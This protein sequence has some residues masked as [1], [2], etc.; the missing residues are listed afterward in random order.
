MYVHG[1]ITHLDRRIGQE[2]WAGRF[3]TFCQCTLTQPLNRP[4]DGDDLLHF[5]DFVI[6]KLRPSLAE[7]PVPIIMWCSRDFAPWSST[8][9]LSTPR[10]P[11]TTLH[12]TMRSESRRHHSCQAAD[13]RNF[14]ATGMAQFYA[15]VAAAIWQNKNTFLG[16]TELSTF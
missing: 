3:N 7:K 10:H 5:F 16:M 1:E 14:M 9:L 8:V 12:G 15:G 11:N 6:D 4:F 13:Q 2:L